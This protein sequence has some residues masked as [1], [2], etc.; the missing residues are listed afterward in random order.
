[1]FQNLP[2]SAAQEVR[3]SSSGVT[4]CIIMKNDGV[5]YHQLSPHVS[6][7]LWKH[8]CVL[9]LR[10]SSILIQEHCSSFVNMVLWRSHYPYD[11]QRSTHCSRLT[12]LSPLAALT[13]LKSLFHVHKVGSSRTQNSFSNPS[14]ALPTSQLILQP[15]RCCTY[16]TVH[17]PT[18]LSLLLRHKLFT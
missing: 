13:H 1:M 7:S 16:V 8:S 12:V 11:I 17:S 2:L 5:L 9:R 15:F 4:P 6:R 18:L 3:D 10:A 14:V